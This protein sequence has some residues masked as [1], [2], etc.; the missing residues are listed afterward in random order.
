MY[1]RILVAFDAS[2]TSRHALATAIWLA[3][4]A[5]ARLRLVHAADQSPWFAGDRLYGGHSDELLK[6]WRKGGQDI[7]DEGTALAAAGGVEAD[8]LLFDRLGEPL[9]DVVGNAAMLWNAD[10]IVVGTHG[11]RGVGRVLMGSGA[12][13]IIRTAPTPVLVVRPAP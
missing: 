13:Q 7:L 11:R 3:R 5:G 9:S 12:E 10:L 4:S 1:K 6:T 2:E 8:N